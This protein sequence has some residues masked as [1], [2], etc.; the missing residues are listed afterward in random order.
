MK[1]TVIFGGTFNPIHHA[2]IEII[3]NILKLSFVEK[4]IVMP[5]ATP[6]HKISDNLACD[7]D[8][9]QMCRLAVSHRDRVEVSD[10]EIMHG[11]KSY[12]YETIKRFKKANKQTQIAIV[13]GGDMIV[14]FKEWYKYAEI[15]KNTDIIAVRRVGIDN[16]TFDRAVS[17]LINEGARISVLKNTVTGIS[18]TE[19]RHHINDKD[20][21]L[22]FLNEEVYNYIIN[23]NLYI[24]D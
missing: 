23:N 9:L 5:T 8:R 22:R 11:G 13:C 7:S 12:T 10:D 17:E 15:I 14:T 18:S 21:L 20:Y 24:E 16:V 2:H 6:P 3:E 19:I 4:V 1:K